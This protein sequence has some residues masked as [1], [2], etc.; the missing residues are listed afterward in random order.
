M[1]DTTSRLTAAL[2]AGHNADGGWPYYRGKASRLEPTAWSAIA[3][4]DSSA[5]AETARVLARW[6]HAGGL[7]LEHPGGIPNYAFHALALIALA[8]AG[9]EHEIGTTALLDALTKVKGITLD[10]PFGKHQDNSLQGWSWI[11]E[12]FSWAEP[13]AWSLLVL[14]KL[15]NAGVRVDASRIDEGERVLI[16]R[17]CA[18]GGWNYGNADANG[19]D[20]RAY[21]PTTAI[22]VLAMQDRRDVEV[23]RSIGY[24]EQHA[25]A[26]RSGGALALALI[27]LEACAR[28]IDHVRTALE[29]QAITTVEFGNFAVIASALAALQPRGGHAA[30]GM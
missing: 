4:A 14:K 11:A 20:L 21:V 30:F 19:Q 2:L 5:G 18:S 9:V 24:L 22:G 7:L 3:L 15:R 12:T 27:A 6:P 16:N 23:V 28:P 8:R 13:T 25:T 29:E 17:S 26:E 10:S 1:S